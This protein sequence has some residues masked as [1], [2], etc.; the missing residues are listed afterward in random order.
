VNEIEGFDFA[1]WLKNTVSKKDFVAMKMD[2]EGTEFDLIPRLF[3]TRAICLIDEIFLECHYNQWQRCCLGERSPKYEKT[4]GQ[5]LDIF[6]SL[7]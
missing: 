7:S 5:C 4:Y 2:V 3:E 6:S 1:E